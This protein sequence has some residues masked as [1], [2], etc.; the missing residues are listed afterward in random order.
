MLFLYKI[1][2]D[3]PEATDGTSDQQSINTSSSL[4]LSARKCDCNFATSGLKLESLN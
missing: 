3:T 4:I 2:F 1:R